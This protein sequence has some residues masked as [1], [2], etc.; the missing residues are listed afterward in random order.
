VQEEE[1]LWRRT[2]LRRFQVVQCVVT[3][4]RSR[5]G[6]DVEVTSPGKYQDAFID[7][8]HL[9]DD[10]L[11]PPDEFPPVGSVLDAITIAFMPNGELRLSARPSAVARR[12]EM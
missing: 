11:V 2:G 10:V 6:V 8:A 7:F 1:D 12:K 3:E 4:H 9:A 5:F